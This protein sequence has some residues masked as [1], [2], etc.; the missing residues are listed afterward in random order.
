MSEHD[1]GA[2]LPA[3][4]K[5]TP[6][7]DGSGIRPGLERWGVI[8]GDRAE[9]GIFARKRVLMAPGLNHQGLVQALTHR[10]CSIRYADPI[11]YFGL[12]DVP[13]VGASGTLDQVA[14][15]TLDRLQDEPFRRIHPQAGAP[16]HARPS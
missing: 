1:Q 9:P 6:V 8:L 16:G 14:S 10:G 15:R 12:P 3:L 2:T 13:G 11:I 4:A 5:K 7:V